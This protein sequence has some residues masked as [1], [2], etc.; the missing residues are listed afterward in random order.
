MSRFDGPS[1]RK[2]PKGPL[3]GIDKHN[4]PQLKV[5]KGG[6]PETWQQKGKGAAQKAQASIT[7]LKRRL[8]SLGR[9]LSSDSKLP[10]DIRISHEREVQALQHELENLML[11]KA[12]SEMIGRYHKVRFF[13][14]QKA[15]RRLK[16]TTKALES[17]E[18]AE[19]KNTLKRKAHI[20]EV[21]VNYPQYYPY[22]TPYV[23]L[24]K[25]EKGV[26]GEDQ[27]TANDEQDDGAKGN[28]EIWRQVELAMRDGSLERLK[29]IVDE[30]EKEKVHKDVASLC[31]ISK[32]SRKAQNGDALDADEDD[33][34][35]T[36]FFE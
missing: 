26:Q 17:C 4:R 28:I 34:T 14:R 6:G 35:G 1:T 5:K 29:D 12:R 7:P 21:D 33:E 27:Y 25:K 11:D 23:S 32:G 24:W 22:M 8:R 30:A 36:G 10:A 16:K 20:A 15:T 3:H 31:K 9:L 13:E 18:N 19:E 2:H